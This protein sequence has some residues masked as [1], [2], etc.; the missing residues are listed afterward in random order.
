M[1]SGRLLKRIIFGN[2]DGAV[3]RGWSWKET[4]WVDCLCSDVRASIIAGDWKETS[5]EAGVYVETVTKGR[6]RFV[7]T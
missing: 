1:S 2:L 7:A 6:W 3:R 4:E 5:L